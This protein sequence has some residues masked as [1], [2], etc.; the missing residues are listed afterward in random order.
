[1]PYKAY[2]VSQVKPNCIGQKSEVALTGWA[3]IG[4]RQCTSTMTGTRVNLVG[5][6]YY[7]EAAGS[8]HTWTGRE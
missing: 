5:R 2:L 4:A 8:I 1:M 3:D 6:G 7:N